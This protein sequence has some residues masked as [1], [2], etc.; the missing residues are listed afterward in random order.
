MELKEL[1]DKTLKL[2]K[3]KNTKE[4]ISEMMRTVERNDLQTY[5]KFAEMVEELSTDWLQKI[6]QY[7]EADRKEK[8]QDYTPASLARLTAKLS[9]DADAVI[10]MCAGS[11][12]LTIQKWNLKHDTKFILYEIDEN[13]IPALLFN[14]AV[15]NIECVVHQADVLQQE[16]ISTWYI[17]KGEKFGL[18]K[19]EG[20][21]PSG[22]RVLISNPP[23]NMKWIA[24]PFAQLQTRFSRCELPPESNANYAFILTALD[25]AERACFILPQSVLDSNDMREKVI[26]QY[27]IENN[28]IESV[29]SCPDKMFEST[30]ISTCIVTFDRAKKTSYIE[31]V[32]MR[33]KYT[34]ENREQNGQFGGKAHTN[35]TYIKNLKSFSEEQIEDALL[36]IQERKNIAGYC[37]PVTIEDVKNSNYRLTPARYIDFIEEQNLHRQYADIISDI[38]R[39]IKEKNTCKLTINET[40][41]KSLGFDLE[42]Y[43]S[44]AET[45]IDGLIEKITGQKIEKE[46]YFTATR[47]KNEI[48]FENKSKD[49]IS[50]IFMMIFNMWK[51]HIFYLNQEE[52]RYLAELR[53]ALLP[54]LMSGKIEIPK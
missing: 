10:D 48:K 18:I 27:L 25:M 17:T 16:T 14:M 49:S 23:F 35:R 43:K 42:L 21:E 5:E 32:D 20:M 11:G 6:F 46:D 50:S 30:A 37:K 34:V 7:H 13:V 24:P 45:E 19:S 4:L 33:Q 39:I 1:T 22:E 36:C 52:N 44:A 54:D 40:I 47:N 2:F 9:G 12:A 28:L 8:K 41:A 26:R 15:R 29:I 51:Q 3:A 38:N 53:D 31:M